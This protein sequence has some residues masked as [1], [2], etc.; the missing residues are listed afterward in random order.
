VK[1]SLKIDYILRDLPVYIVALQRIENQV[2]GFCS[3]K[4]AGLLENLQNS[5]SFAFFAAIF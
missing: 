4:R 1:Q 5:Q 3:L 2:S